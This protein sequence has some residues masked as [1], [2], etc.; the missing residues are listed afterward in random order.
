MDLLTAN[1]HLNF[2][3]TNALALKGL[4]S[5]VAFKEFSEQYRNFHNAILY[6]LEKD[7]LNEAFRFATTL[8]P[9][10][11]GTKRL[12]EGL[13]LMER[14]LALPGGDDALRG[15]ICFD[16]GYL[17]FWKGDYEQAAKFHQEAI[18]LGRLAHNSTVVAIALT[19]LARIALV[20][21]L[22]KARRL[23]LEALDVASGATDLLGSSHATH[24]LGVVAQMSGNFQEAREL[25]RRRIALARKAGNFV[26][27]SSELGNLSM[28]ERQLGNLDEA[29]ALAIESLEIDVK[30]GDELAIPWKVNG[31]LSIAV[32]RED[33]EHA[34]TLLGIADTAMR[35]SGGDWP[36][37]ELVHYERAVSILQKK[38]PLKQF[39]EIKEMGSRMSYA[40][41]MDYAL[42]RSPAKLVNV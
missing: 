27:V 36:P 1:L 6:F 21:D 14:M 9:F 4:A 19:G 29:E 42:S 32:D 33:Y 23:C 2:V 26:G 37:D 39:E 10:W 31:L 11:M 13:V 34:A 40:E 24:V 8:V 12:D 3:E 30:R 17:K 41:A 28:V 18:R 15:R 35:V 7:Y 5:K 20:N 38:M 22:G 25:M 16:V